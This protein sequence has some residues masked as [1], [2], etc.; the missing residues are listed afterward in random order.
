MVCFEFYNEMNSLPWLLKFKIVSNG[1]WYELYVFKC[2]RN[3]LSM[4]VFG[5][6]KFLAEIN[7]SETRAFITSWC[8]AFSGPR[9]KKKVDCFVPAVVVDEDEEDEGA[10]MSFKIA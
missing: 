2:L 7:H 5:H 8:R 6:F 9:R 10:K 4:N 1:V 3:L